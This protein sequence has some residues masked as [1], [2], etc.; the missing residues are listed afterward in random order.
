MATTLSEFTI[1]TT[2]AISASTMVIS[3]AS[4][5]FFVGSAVFT[6]SSAATETVT[7]WRL[8]SGTAATAINFLAKRDVPANKTWICAEL[9]G[10]VISGGSKIQASSDTAA[11]VNANLS[12][13]IET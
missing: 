7:V 2:L 11:V 5:R 9:I 1:D 13:T 3:T 10:S 6:N 8:G 12:G 4:S